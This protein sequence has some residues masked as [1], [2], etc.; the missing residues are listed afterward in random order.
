MIRAVAASMRSAGSPC[1]L[2][3]KRLLSIAISGVKGASNKPGLANASRTHVRTSIGRDIRP[4]CSSIPSSQTEITDT[5]R[6]PPDSAR[7]IADKALRESWLA[8]PSCAHNQQCV[9][10]SSRSS[11]IGFPLYIDGSNDIADYLHGAFH[12]PDKAHGAFDNRNQLGHGFT[13]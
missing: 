5:R 6:R 9:S 1:N 2:P 3:G 12:A 4:F 11:F 7:R 10:S 8:S 13:A